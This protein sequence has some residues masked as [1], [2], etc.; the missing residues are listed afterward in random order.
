MKNKEVLPHVTAK[1]ANCH[2][3]GECH[4]RHQRLTSEG[5]ND[6]YLYVSTT[7]F[8]LLSIGTL[9]EGVSIPA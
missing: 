1:G 9:D 3:V 6:S 5:D 4:V 7:Q 8:C 2:K